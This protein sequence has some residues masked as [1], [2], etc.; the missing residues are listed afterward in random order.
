MLFTVDI[1]G[2]DV[3]ERGK[4]KI[5]RT[6]ICI[7]NL[8]N[9]GADVN[10]RYAIF[11]FAYYVRVCVYLSG[12]FVEWD[13]IVNGEKTWD[14]IREIFTSDSDKCVC[15]YTMSDKIKGTGYIY[16]IWRYTNM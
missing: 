2:T 10:V 7:S 13:G 6:F 14:K 11:Y 1:L 9:A 12:V 5:R 8:R 3:Y 15:V 4:K 16:L